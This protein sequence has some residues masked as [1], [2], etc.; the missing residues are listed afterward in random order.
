MQSTTTTTQKS[1]IVI[2]KVIN[3][4]NGQLIGLEG[5]TE[6]KDSEYINFPAIIFCSTATE[7]NEIERSIVDKKLPAEEVFIKARQAPTPIVQGLY[8]YVG[9]FKGLPV[10]ARN[11]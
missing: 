5:E 10:I 9:T 4:V 2:G 1:I 7:S 11:R 8:Q 3:V 6:E